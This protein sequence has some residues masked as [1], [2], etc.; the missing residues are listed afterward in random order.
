MIIF[1]NLY[2]ILYTK[3]IKNAFCY[4]IVFEIVFLIFLSLLNKLLSKGL[5]VTTNTFYK[6]EVDTLT[7]SSSIF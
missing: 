7:T 1:K 6:V 3:I 2:I 4:F 5:Y